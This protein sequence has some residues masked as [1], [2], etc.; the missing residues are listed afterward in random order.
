MQPCLY[1][2]LRNDMASMTPGRACA[3]ASHATSLF[4]GYM[5]QAPPDVAGHWRGV[6]KSRYLTWAIGP[7]KDNET[8]LDWIEH[9]RKFGTAIVLGADF[10]QLLRL[11]A[12]LECHNDTSSEDFK[13]DHGLVV[14]ESYGVKD[15]AY[16]HLIE[17]P[18]ALWV[19]GDPEV[20][21]LMT[22]HL[23]LF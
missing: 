7:R 12:Q 22:K 2:V 14:D 16:R 10:D 17:V 9:S 23:P 6:R 11:K 19:F 13:I 20:T 5:N 18:T 1:I 3:Q 15:G 21:K 4:E 8:F